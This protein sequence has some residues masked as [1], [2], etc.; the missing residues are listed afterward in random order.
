MPSIA[1]LALTDCM[2]VERPKAFI[3]VED[4]GYLIAAIQT[5]D[6]TGSEATSRVARRVG[7][8]AQELEGV[9]TSVLARGLQR[10]ELRPTRPIR[11]RRSSSSRN[12]ASATKPELRAAALTDQASG[13]DPHEIRGGGRRR[14]PAAADPR[15]LSQTG[16][17]EF[18][19]ED[20]DGQGVE[21]LARSPTSSSTR[22]DRQR[23]RARRRLFTP[24]TVNVPQLR[25]KLDRTK[26]QRLDVAVSD[27]FTV[28]QTNL[29]GY[30][31]N[32]FNLYGKV[33]K[34]MVQ[35]EG[36]PAQ[37]KTDIGSLYVSNRKRD[38]A[39]PS[40]HWAM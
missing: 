11:R 1:L 18:M 29:G 26:A 7:K 9:A 38:S 30:Y 2:L 25:F 37:P 20:R 39:F 31:V 28:L 13:G 27:V 22:G 32:D 35:A 23:P 4:Q 15:A 24:F 21:A 19:I 17:F 5:P 36:I 12:G 10:L 34:V 6:G 8:I 16:G 40:T 14:A 3:P 33:W